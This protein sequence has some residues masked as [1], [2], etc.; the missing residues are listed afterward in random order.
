MLMTLFF[1]HLLD[2]IGLQHGSIVLM[3]TVRKFC[4]T[5]MYV[6]GWVIMSES[7]IA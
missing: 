4:N 6:I 3:M 7:M 2:L 5:I 1:P